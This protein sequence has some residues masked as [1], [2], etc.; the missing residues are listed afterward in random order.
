MG[1]WYGTTFLWIIVFQIYTHVHIAVFI[2]LIKVPLT[3]FLGLPSQQ[4]SISKATLI[5][6]GIC[7]KQTHK[8]W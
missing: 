7:I 5:D 2:T 8:N 1:V 4:S 3:I 6:M